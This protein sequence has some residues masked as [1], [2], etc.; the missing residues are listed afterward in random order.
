MVDIT[1][2]M[3]E[4]INNMLSCFST[5]F[6]TLSDIQFMGISLLTY[7]ISL[8]ILSAVVPVVIATVRTGYS[9]SFHAS[10][11]VSKSYHEKQSR[12]REAQEL[13]NLKDML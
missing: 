11:N 12:S 13:E 9:A 10:E 2:F 6:K 7:S 3:Q 4:F 5:I 8:L 1:V